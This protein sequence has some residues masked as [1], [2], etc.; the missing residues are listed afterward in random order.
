MSYKIAIASGKGGTGKTTVSVNLFKYLSEKYKKNVF[1]TDCDV[2]EP[3]CLIFFNDAVLLNESTATKLVPSIEKEK[4]TYCGKCAEW[5]EFNAI[6]I[7]K[8]ARFT[9]VNAT[10]CHSCGACSVACNFDAITEHSDPIGKIS[11]YESGFGCELMVG[12]LNIG[13]TMQ[14]MMIEKTKENIPEN[15]KVLLFDS[16]PGTSCPV[17]ETISDAD[18]VVLV[19][20]PTPFGFHDLKLMIDL[21]TEMQLPFGIVI[22]KAGLGNNEVYKFIDDNNFE[23]LGEIPFSKEYASLYSTGNI[24]KNIPLEIDLLFRQITERLIK[25]IE[26]DEG[27]HHTER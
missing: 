11:R 16:P 7:I 1:L 5:C 19:T 25:K 17:V 27:N 10:L 2:E 12:R 9:E 4:C 22:N 18:Y 8:K 23:L 14:T 20:E 24:L 6:S 3:N 21:V 13:S 15:H 26:K